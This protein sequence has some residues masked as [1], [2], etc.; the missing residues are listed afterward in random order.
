[1][2]YL[3]WRWLH[4]GSHQESFRE[5]HYDNP[6]LYWSPFLPYIGRL[7][8]KVAPMD[9]M[10]PNGPRGATKGPKCQIGP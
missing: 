1:M 6:Y 8:G 4:D 9:P 7:G 10:G 5:L 3:A 2:C